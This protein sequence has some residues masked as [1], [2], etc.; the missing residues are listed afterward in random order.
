MPPGHTLCTTL[1]NIGVLSL[2]SHGSM[3]HT[4]EQL[5]LGQ[6]KGKLEEHTARESKQEAHP[7]LPVFSLPVTGGKNVSHSWRLLRM[8]VLQQA[9]LE[10]FY[11]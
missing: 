4:V 8:T 1:S 11:Q 6:S 9:S 3:W 7:Y 10:N 2:S 5:C